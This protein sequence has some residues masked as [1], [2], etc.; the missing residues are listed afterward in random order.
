[1]KPDPLGLQYG[2]AALER[3]GAMPFAARLPRS[4]IAGLFV[5]GLTAMTASAAAPVAYDD[6]ITAKQDV[7]LT[8]DYLLHNDK[9]ADGNT[10]S[11]TAVGAP[12]HGVLTS[13]GGNSYRYTPTAGW[14][15]RDSFTYTTSDG[16]GGT[17]TGLVSISVNAAYDVTVA[18]NTILAGVTQIAP[19]AG[20]RIACAWGA[21][22][23]SISNYR[24]QDEH[25][26]MISAATMGAGRVVA[27]ADP[28]WLD[29]NTLAGQFN[30]GTFYT[31][32]I[33]WIAN[34]T[35][36]TIPIVTMSTEVSTW[37]TAQGYTSVTTTNTTG[38]AAALAGK[39][40]FVGLV[41]RTLSNANITALKNFVQGGGG[42]FCCEGTYLPN[43]T[44]TILREA[45]LSFGVGTVDPFPPPFTINRADRVFT[46]DGIAAIFQN[47]SGYPTS[48]VMSAAAIA[49]YLCEELPESDIERA[50]LLFLFRTVSAA[51]TPTP[52]APVTNAVQRK[53]LD[54]ECL[55]INSLP[56]AEM[57]AHRAALPVSAA[58]PRVTNATFGLVPPPAAHD[59]K[60]IYTPFY[61]APGELVTIQFPAALTAKTLDVR[62][63]HLRSADGSTSYP[64]MPIQMI[65][66]DVAAAQ[67]QVANPHGGLI[68]IIVPSNVTWTGTQNITVTGAVQAPYFKLG[69]TTDAQWVAGIRDRGTPFGVIDSPEATLVV[70]ADKWL[71]T[72]TDPEAVITEWDYFCG[73]VREF[74]VH[75]PGRQLPVHHD[76]FPAGGVSTYPQ[77]YNLTDEITN[78]LDLKAGAYSLT[79]HEYGHICD[80]GNIMFYE[81]GETSPNMGGKWIQETA[82]KYSWKQEL[83]TGRINNYLSSLSDDLYN[84]HGHHAV[85]WKG[86]VFDILSVEFGAALIKDS[87]FALSTNPA[88]LSDQETVDEWARQL[89]NRSGYNLC[90][91]LI[92]WQIIPSAAVQTE[93]SALPDWMVVE[94]VPES[95]TLV[96]GSP[97][98]FVDP[99]ENDFSYD[100][101]LTLTSVSQP[102]S[103]TITNN[104]NGTYT[105][106][107]AAGFTGSASF[108]YTVTNTTGN[109]FTSTVPVKVV[110]AANDPKLV[111]FDGV[112]NGS[113]WTT[114]LLGKTYTSMV[115]V[116]QP[117][118]AT[119]APPLATRI[120]N[121]SGSS[122][123][124]RLDRIDGSSTP[125][126]ATAVRFLVVEAGVYTPETHGLKMEAVKFTSSTTDRGGSFTGTTRDFAYTGYEHYFI[127]VVFG[128]VMTS[129]DSRW[130][131]FWF[132]ERAL[133][134]V[135]LGKHVGE[136]PVT[137]R[138]DETIGY[139]VMEAGN[140]QFGNCQV[141][142]GTTDADAYQNVTSFDHGGAVWNL[143]NFPSIQSALILAAT[144]RDADDTP[145]GYV[146]MQRTAAGNG[147]S[148][149]LAE[150]AL[151]DVE[152]TVAAKIGASYLLAHHTAL[153]SNDSG[154]WANAAGGLWT[155]AGNWSG[156][157]IANGA[158][159]TADFSTLN[160]TADTTV[161]LNGDR[162]IGHL[163][164]DDIIASNHWL[165][166]SGSG[167]AL[168]LDILGGTPGIVV[169]DCTATLNVVLAGN[170]GFTKTGNG[171]LTLGGANSYSGG[172]TISHGSDSNGITIAN[173]SALGSGPVLVNGAQNFSH[174]VSVNAGLSIANALTLK[175]GNGGGNRAVLGLAASS[176]WGGPITVDNTSAN[177]IA[178]ISGNGT[179]AATASLV[180]GNIGF[181]TLGSGPSLVLRSNHGKVSGS[182]SL[183]TG[184][185]Q[186][187][188]GS[189]WEFSNASNTWG[190]LDVAHASAI[191]TVG[192]AN[193]L[194]PGG[195][196]T[197]TV[198]GTLN[199]NNQAGSS[200]YSQTIAGLSGNVKVG[201]LTGAA[202]LT[203]NTAANQSSSG[204][205]SGAISLVK[206]GAAMQTLS[207]SNTYSGTTTVNGGTL[208]VT[209]S[210]PG[211]M[212]AVNGGT[213]SGTGTL[214]GATTVNAGGT[215]APGSG[216]IGTLTISNALTLA[217]TAAFELNKAG[218]TLTG[219]RVQSVTSLTYGGT[220]NVTATGSALVAGDAFTLF[221][222][223]S[224]SGSFASINLPVLEAGLVWNTSQLGVSGTVSVMPAAYTVTY[225]AGANGAITGSTPQTVN[226]GGSSSAVTAVPN[227][228]YGFT[229]WSDGST[230]N[231]RTDSNVTANLTVTANFTATVPGPIPAQWTAAKTGTVSATTSSTYLNGT[232]HVTGGGSRISNTSDNFYFVSQPWS[233][234]GT[235]TARVVSLQNTGSAARAGVMMRE[236]S[237]SG[238]RSVFIG[239][240]PANSAQWVR[241][242]NTG[243]N[244]SAT[245]SSGKAAPYWVRLTREGNTFTSYISANGTTWTQLA[246][247]NIS[248]SGNYSL[249]MAACSGASG[250]T[251]ASVFDNVSVSSTLPSPPVNPVFSGD[252]LPKLEG[253]TLEDGTVD[254]NITGEAAGIWTLE[255]STDFVT[256]SPLQTMTLEAGGL[257]H[258]EADERG[259]K[260]FLRLQSSP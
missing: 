47:P 53:L 138:A 29:M 16:T 172:T 1:M 170:K 69:E 15:G 239:L 198:A 226:Y 89:S 147:M 250:T 234:T 32:S 54:L 231:P 128:Q 57:T 56:V 151:G 186:L 25:N 92:E 259:A 58:A 251:V 210:L 180:S 79:L 14:I 167:G 211:G 95:L 218:S 199:L 46:T 48:D 121:A 156:G 80:H 174:S 131:S 28:A 100:G 68:Q 108:T 78:S 36:K 225:T 116:A 61:A 55:G 203:L 111:A 119:G 87:V 122:F 216:G 256:W 38:L 233:G 133:N 164:F 137:Q 114:V 217:G 163:L 120:R 115:V 13:L 193:T 67:V 34:T 26:P 209:G 33:S 35:S 77:S 257:Q 2:S 176:T 126:G 248:M 177:G 153:E 235:L 187:L 49:E 165:L 24:G 182:I 171:T 178:V 228:G 220:L 45:G 173:A 3:N 43:A 160:L 83:T 105:Y 104:N 166:N 98:I 72:L 118:V 249:G 136:D 162:T 51:V 93:L 204:V 168:T 202:T 158:G 129:N 181:S 132:K 185:L 10:L 30:T 230:A 70:D 135:T 201:L 258:S 212:T 155:M 99:S 208:N 125:V 144:P 224:Y 206:S 86:T 190:T 207:G 109:V 5:S 52:Q 91:L 112:A 40:M 245:T 154:V 141:Q 183:S 106:T 22:A 197:S 143:F 253:F 237:A 64:V 175:R 255:E 59:T 195:V 44:E 31:N 232:F 238:S 113:G 90:P 27:V 63:S 4:F 107:P 110:A 76:Y 194:A 81:F 127:P 222:A 75:N 65:N 184:L 73:K 189:K 219:D 94:R 244:S 117:L 227:S 140:H 191:V 11:I 134:R 84:N 241:R 223:T 23:A 6:A 97:V 142:A 74:Y 42:L 240:T 123:E 17:D 39:T 18:R 66:F 41:P 260:R 145:D 200:A 139:I 130:S 196:L 62:V 8:L 159:Q 215:L 101:G 71:R 60:T 169:N 205:I 236:S 246:S 149:Y 188:D 254:F 19:T 243:G 221:S 7:Q 247:A 242:S 229:N 21:T 214:G 152:A 179:N 82:R 9:D 157:T 102:T 50:R 252:P 146:T 103:G 85:D 88:S 124:I 161:A 96:Q 37:L 192:A 148:A 213:L 20:S 12:A 150:D